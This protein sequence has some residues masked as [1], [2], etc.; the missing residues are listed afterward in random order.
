MADYLT[1]AEVGRVTGL[2]AHTIR[3][4]EKQFPLLL[5]IERSKGGHRIYRDRHLQALKSVLKLLKEDK[6]S[7]RD[8]RKA[9]GEADAEEVE[10]SN[11]V[12]LKRGEEVADVSRSLC[13][14]LERLDSL[15]QSNERRDI[16]LESLIRKS[17]KD[18]DAELMTQISRCRAETRET[19]KM[20]RMLMAQ[21]KNSN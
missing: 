3:Y 2:A 19:M 8:T 16:L 11:G 18:D 10:N 5:D 4:Y 20:Y 12:S 17:S 9:L 7:I 13:V 1:I 14:V 6:L 21:W 15:C